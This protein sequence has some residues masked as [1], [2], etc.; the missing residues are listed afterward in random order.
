VVF[1]PR[2]CLIAT[3]RTTPAFLAVLALLVLPYGCAAPV[4][5]GSGGLASGD[6][7][8][9][10][11]SGQ[12]PLLPDPALTPGDTFPVTA[13]DACTSGYSE[14]VRNVS[15]EEKSAVF[16]EYG[17]AHHHKGEFEVDHLISLELGGSND[18]KNLWPQSYE[19]QPWNAHV[20]D[21]LEN[22]LHDRVCD[23]LMTLP[24]AQHLIAGNWISAYKQIFNTNVPF[25]GAGTSSR[26]HRRRKHGDPYEGD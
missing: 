5:N 16:A 26:F 14:S 17:I 6:D 12:P 18:I 22:E 24:E 13:E 1:S 20:K 10:Q 11:V 9:V 15:P 21:Q 25:V 19:T 2:T 23:G 4:V 7:V 8:P 3:A